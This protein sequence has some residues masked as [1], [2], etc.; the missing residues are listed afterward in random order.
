MSL[1]RKTT[2]ELGEIH[3]SG[4]KLVVFN[5]PN[6]GTGVALTIY[7][8]IN[9]IGGIAHI[10][11]PESSLSNTYSADESPGKYANLAVPALVEKFIEAGGQKRGTIVRMAGGAQLFNFGGGGGNIM[12]IGAR[13]ATAIR[14]AMSKLGFAI[15]KADTGGNKSKSIR[16]IMATGQLHVNIIGGKDYLL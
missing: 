10:V 15:E 11:M 8:T 4:D 6:L 2:V 5:I 13:N 3:V 16:F 12:N 1:Q 9:R 14:A 7:D